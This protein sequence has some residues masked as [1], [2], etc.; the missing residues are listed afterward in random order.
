MV[1]TMERPAAPRVGQVT[2]HSI[3]LIWEDALQLANDR[4]ATATAAKQLTGDGRVKVQ[5]EQRD[6][7]ESWTGV[8]M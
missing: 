7:T 1:A 3:E 4:L 2:H 6:N 5:L 8:Y